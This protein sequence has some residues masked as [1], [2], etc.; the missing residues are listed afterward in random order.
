MNKGILK[1][2]GFSKEV[3]AVEHNICP[4]CGKKIDVTKEFKDSLSRREYAISGL[5]QDC[6]DKVFGVTENN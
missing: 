3:E 6:Q 2:A 4:F 1:K 5:C